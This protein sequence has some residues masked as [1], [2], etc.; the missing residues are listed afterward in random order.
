MND[1]NIISAQGAD[2]AR[3]FPAEKIGFVDRLL[4]R[5]R[6]GFIEHKAT[7]AKILG[8]P[9]FQAQF[10]DTNFYYRIGGVHPEKAKNYNNIL[11]IQWGIGS[12]KADTFDDQVAIARA[13]GI[14]YTTWIIFDPA[15]PML[16][17]DQARNYAA[18]PDVISNPMFADVEQPRSTTRCVSYGEL[19]DIVLILKSLSPFK[20]GCYSR[21]NIFE[22]IF[23]NGFP[24]WMDDVW[25]W[26]AQYL[27]FYDGANWIQALYYETFLDNW[28]WAL[29]PSVVKSKLY[30]DEKWRKLVIAWQISSKGRAEK[31][32][33][34]LKLP[35]GSPAMKSCD[36]NLSMD[37]VLVFIDKLFTG[38]ST[39]PPDP[40]S[41]DCPE[42]CQKQ[43]DAIKADIVKLYEKTLANGGAILALENWSQKFAQDVASSLN[44]HTTDI[45]ILT[46]QLDTHSHDGDTPPVPPDP[47]EVDFLTVIVDNPDDNNCAVYRPDIWDKACDDE[48]EGYDG[49]IGK[50][51]CE[52]TNKVFTFE[53]KST[54]AIYAKAWYS[55]ADDGHEDDPVIKGAYG[56]YYMVF[57]GQFDGALVP[58]K[59]VRILE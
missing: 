33:A 54:F 24:D 40:D 55:C 59:R 18:D 41:G 2:W 9:D 10:V 31:Y 17:P 5:W 29:P 1:K 3:D 43:I 58:A 21:V 28:S 14:P 32:I 57:G 23:I 49:P 4:H 27:L 50:P 36:L 39:P 12:R 53:N 45:E 52:G 37:S 22:S 20:V 13:N 19:R 7:A 11:A 25:Q 48:P 46:V 47:P 26:I 35:D 6:G 30:S 16:I 42:D 44:K 51:L 56:D 8:F 34:P 38:G 15:D